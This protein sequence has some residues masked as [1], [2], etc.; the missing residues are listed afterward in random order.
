MY[1]G[2]ISNEDGDDDDDDDDNCQPFLIS[3]TGAKTD[4]KQGISMRVK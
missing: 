4:A 2:V 1:I 3:L